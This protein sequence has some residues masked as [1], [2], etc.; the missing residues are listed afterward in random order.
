VPFHDLPGGISKQ[1]RQVT[2]VVQEFFYLVGLRA[3]CL[4]ISIFWLISNAPFPR[5]FDPPLPVL[6]EEVGDPIAT[7]I[8]R[9]SCNCRNEF[10]LVFIST[11]DCIAELNVEACS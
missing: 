5:V 9:H 11:T 2:V 7:I 1:G 6:V 4:F 10:P 8:R 3:E